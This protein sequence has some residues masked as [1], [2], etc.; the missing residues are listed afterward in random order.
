MNVAFV[1]VWLL[2]GSSPRLRSTSNSGILDLHAVF[3]FANHAAL[4]QQDLQHQNMAVHLIKVLIE[5]NDSVNE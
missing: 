3:V 2:L 1:F 4:L 5:L